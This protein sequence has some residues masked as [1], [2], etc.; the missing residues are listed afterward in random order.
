MQL[1]KQ[2][3]RRLAAALV[4]PLML[5]KSADEVRNCLDAEIPV[6]A[7]TRAEYCGMPAGM[8]ALMFAASLNRADAVRALL[9]AGANSELTNGDGYTAIHIAA[10]A[11]HNETLEILVSAS[12]RPRLSELAVCGDLNRVRSALSVGSDRDTTEI[13]L[14]LFVACATDH[15]SV[16]DALVAIGTPVDIR[17]AKGRTPLHYAARYA[18]PS[19]AYVLLAAGADPNALDQDFNAP[20]NAI[21]PGGSARVAQRLAVVSILIG[22][23]A[24]LD[25]AGTSGWTPL[26]TAAFDADVELIRLLLE[27]GADPNRFTNTQYYE[28]YE[29]C[30]NTCVLNL[31]LSKKCAEC[32]DLLLSF[33]ADPTLPNSA[34]I[35]T[36]DCVKKWLQRKKISERAMRIALMVGV[37]DGR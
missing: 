31:A 18:A 22:A 19:A 9:C 4:T 30:S 25:A 35:T 37:T 8:T 16:C 32:V 36:Q 20:L 33:G 15:G 28:L 21:F 27:N 1:K 34:G 11:K 10:M 17:D 6:D 13:T 5:A 7:A 12:T 24:Q 26:M 14:A 2:F 29:G 23:G 3:E